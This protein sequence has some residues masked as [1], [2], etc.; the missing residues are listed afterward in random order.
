MSKKRNQLKKPKVIEKKLN[1]I[2][3]TEFL[4]KTAK[5]TISSYEIE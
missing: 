2:F 3:S 1:T 5:N 4:E